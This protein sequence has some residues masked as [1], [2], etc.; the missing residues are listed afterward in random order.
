[1]LVLRRAGLQF[2]HRRRSIEHLPAAVEHE[3]VVRGD[4]RERDRERGA[5][6]IECYL[7]PSEVGPSLLAI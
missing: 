1:M 4:L 3:V 5:E 2:D 6:T 7:M